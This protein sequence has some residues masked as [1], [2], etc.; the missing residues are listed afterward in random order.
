MF[1]DEH[2][3]TL[4][5]AQFGNPV[6]LKF[7]ATI[8]FDMPSDRHNQGGCLSFTDGHA[9]RKRWQAPKISH[10]LGQ[11]PTAEEMPDYRFMQDSMKKPS[12]E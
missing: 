12:D 3:D 8:W 10:Y 11:A 1:I 2:A 6:Q 7:Y 4:L 9:E 5:D